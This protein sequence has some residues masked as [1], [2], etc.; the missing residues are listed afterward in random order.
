LCVSGSEKIK[1][2]PRKFIHKAYFIN[3][4]SRR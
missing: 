2:S 3:N 1:N 4:S